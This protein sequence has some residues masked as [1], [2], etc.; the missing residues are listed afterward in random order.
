MVRS[1][2]KTSLVM[3]LP[4]AQGSSIV[5]SWNCLVL[6]IL[7]KETIEGRILGTSIPMVPLPG[8]GIRI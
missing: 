1:N 5:V 4:I 7:S 3:V 8:I 2:I 6:R